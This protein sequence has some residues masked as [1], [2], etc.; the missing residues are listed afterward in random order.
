MEVLPVV[1]YSCDPLWYT[2][3]FALYV[4][5]LLLV[6][7]I[8]LLLGRVSNNDVEIAEKLLNKFCKLVE[9]YYG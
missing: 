7:A 1:L 4:H 8:R 5:I 6:E 3:G 2:T 9:E